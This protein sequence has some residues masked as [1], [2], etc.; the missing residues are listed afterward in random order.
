MQIIKDVNELEVTLGEKPKD[1]D[2]GIYLK[3]YIVNIN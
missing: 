3:T 1:S 2:S